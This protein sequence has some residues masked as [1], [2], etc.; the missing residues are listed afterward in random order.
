VGSVRRLLGAA[1]AVAAVI[2]LVPAPADAAEAAPFKVVVPDVGVSKITGS[3]VPPVLAA[4]DAATVPALKGVHLDLDATAVTGFAA[5]TV[6]G[7]DC[8]TG[9]DLGAMANPV[10]WRLPQLFVKPKAGTKVGTTGTI[11]LTVSADGYAPVS[12]SA[13]VTVTDE[14]VVAG[15]V[16]ATYTVKDGTEKTQTLL[17]I[18]NLGSE[19]VVGLTFRLVGDPGLVWWPQYAMAVNCRYSVEAKSFYGHEQFCDVTNFHLEPGQSYQVPDAGLSAPDGKP[20]SKYQFQQTYFAGPDAAGITDALRLMPGMHGL[21]KG[22]NVPK[23]IP[24]GTQGKVADGPAALGTLVVEQ[25]SS[26]PSSGG[27]TVSPS[28]T[29]TA[30][31][32]TTAP[33]A[34]GTAAPGDG[35]TGGGGGLPVTGT[36]VTIVAVLGALLLG[37]GAGLFVMSRRRRTRFSA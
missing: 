3:Y 31:V 18:T 7:L 27:P 24:E 33:G 10:D 30:P 34:G 20:G 14:H 19:T 6:P 37:G 15:P 11:K 8:T 35:G 16:T 36:D 32:E 1:A 4:V 28:S 25:P 17:Q 23:R 5:V 26:S 29:A 21:S 22:L 9:C 2:A 13:T 12:G